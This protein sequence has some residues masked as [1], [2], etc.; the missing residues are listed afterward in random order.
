M[1]EFFNFEE[2][3]L[4]L[5]FYYDEPFLSKSKWIL[6]VLSIILF[7]AIPYV[8]LDV[9][10]NLFS[11]MLFLVTFI[12]LVYVCKGNLS[13]FF[14]KVRRKD[15]KIILI[16]LVAYYIYT[17]AVSQLL[18]L[19]G[20]VPQPNAVLDSNMDLIFWIT[21]VI[22]LMGEEL[23]KIILMLLVMKGLYN[24]TDNRKTSLICSILVSLLVFG[25]I[26]YSVYGVL[27]QIILIIG[28]GS[29]FE[30]YI[31]LKTKNVLTSY[32]LHV[33]IDAI[34]LLLT[35]LFGV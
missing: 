9:N 7:I 18:L 30:I 8:P 12:P 22:Q 34:P 20:I 17:F 21:L 24:L 4:D 32:I 1:S 33:L 2:N 25:L 5:P 31:Y 15:M 16:C 28:L 27:A 29:I 11:I 3:E 23:F 19:V 6:L 26:H 13:L 10:E 14:R 35:M